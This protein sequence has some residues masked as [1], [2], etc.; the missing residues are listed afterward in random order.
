MGARRS[1]DRFWLA[2]GR[3]GAREGAGAEARLEAVRGAG[4]PPSGLGDIPVARARVRASHRAV[5]FTALLLAPLGCDSR[6]A[7]RDPASDVFT[8]PAP[9]SFAARVVTSAGTFELELHRSWSPAAV[10][11][12]YHLARLGF[13]EGARFYRVNDQ[14]AQFG[15]TGEPAL[16]TLW[17]GAGLPDEPVV[18]SNVRGAVSF[19]R[20][21]P[22]SRSFIVFI[23][24]SPNT[25]LD[26]L[27]WQGV[28]GFPP[29]GRVRSG[30]EVVDALHDG[31]GEEP[32]LM[33]DSLTTGGNAFL[34]RRFPGL[35]SI[36]GI[37]IIVD[38]DD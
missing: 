21:G 28:V 19:A 31:Y 14:Y 11:R 36:A 2:T 17:L 34:D 8:D 33:E 7:L 35:D 5:A 25:H 26:E 6:A 23:N 13:Y 10:D 3:S 30:M 1:H 27:E 32:L 37:E 16:D 15:F 29:I 9:E 12:F 38:T 22:A 20:G 24:R 4:P 18:D